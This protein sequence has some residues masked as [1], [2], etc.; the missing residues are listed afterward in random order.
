MNC[1]LQPGNKTGPLLSF[2]NLDLTRL[3][4]NW[5]ET[6]TLSP[7]AGTSLEL[8]K[9][10]WGF[11]SQK[12]GFHALSESPATSMAAAQAGPGEAAAGGRTS[13]FSLT[14]DPV[15]PEM[16]RNA[17]APSAPHDSGH[18]LFGEPGPL[19]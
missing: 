10:K 16:T 3:N 11:C 8:P 1:S 2:F 13:V 18:S 6:L 5:E 15:P 14:R 4:P 19:V 12:E 7:V 17:K 9:R